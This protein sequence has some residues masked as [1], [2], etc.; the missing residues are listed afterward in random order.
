MSRRLNREEPVE[1]RRLGRNGP[2][3]PAIG[4]G[5]WK[6]FDVDASGLPRAR[7]VI[8][9]L[10]A[11]EGRFVDSSPMYGRAEQAL[12][13]ALGDLRPDF[14][15]AAKI[16]ASSVANGKAQFQAQLRFFGGVVDVE[17]VHNLVAW[18]DQ[19]AWMQSERERGLIRW[20]GATHF[21]S[22]AFGELERVMRT[23]R[24]DCIQVPYN[25]LERECEHRIL[26]LAEELG[27]GVIVMRP[28]G[29][30]MLLRRNPS[31]EGLGVETWAEA[32]L[33]WCLSDPR[34]TVVIPATNSPEHMAA[35]VRAG[36]PPWFDEEQR[37][38]VV[39][40]AQASF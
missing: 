11:G 8:E 33:K 2:L 34:V 3:V 23:G 10:Y 25:P 16:W 37:A 18:R 38:Q 29:S 21:D 17:Q 28:F 9:S 24:I 13:R 40:L 12:G 30:G 31:L 6:V 5:T 26:P 39:S 14:L 35:N 36:S 27:L 1:I 4:L 7:R 22:S 32:L 15:V 19:L 20:L